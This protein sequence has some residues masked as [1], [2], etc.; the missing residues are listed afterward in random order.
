[1]QDHT[2]PLPINKNKAGNITYWP[3]YDYSSKTNPKASLFCS[4]TVRVP[5]LLPTLLWGIWGTEGWQTAVAGEGQQLCQS[6][7]SHGELT[8]LRGSKSNCR[9]ALTAQPKE[10]LPTTPDQSAFQSGQYFSSEGHMLG[11]RC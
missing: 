6:S 3:S 4:H 8:R 10:L 7:P 5:H 1:M 2:S 9:A 11:C